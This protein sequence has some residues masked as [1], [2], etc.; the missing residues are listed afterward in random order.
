MQYVCYWLH[1]F[2]SDLSKHLVVT[3]AD[4]DELIQRGNLHRT[5]A[6]TNMNEHSSRSHAIFTVFF[7]QVRLSFYLSLSLSSILHWCSLQAKLCEGVP[8]EIH[9]KV[10]LVD[11]AGR[12]ACCA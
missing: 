4:V 11:L 8:S 3:Y 2:V 10:H 7:T 5:T 1:C 9:S 12:C 6:A